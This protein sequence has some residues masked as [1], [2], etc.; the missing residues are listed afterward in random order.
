M[1]ITLF[2]R[3]LLA[4]FR[5]R[6]AW[7]CL[8]VAAMLA[9]AV[10]G[11]AQADPACVKIRQACR[12]AGFEPGNGLQQQCFKPIL[13]GAA[14][15][16]GK[17]LPHVPADVVASCRDAG[18]AATTPAD[19]GA[20]PS[21]PAKGD[22]PRGIYVY[23]EQ[24]TDDAQ[25]EQA[26]AVRGVDGMALV[27]DWATIE[28]SRGAFATATIDSQIAAALRHSLPVELV[29]RAGA[30]TPSW[31]APAAQLK[32][33]YAQHAGATGR[34]E[35][36]DMPP[37]WNANYQHAFAAILKRTA[38]YIRSKGVAISVVKL[39]GIN[40]TSEEVRLPAEPAQTTANCQGGGVNDDAAWQRAKYTPAMLAQAT[41]EIARIFDTAVPSTPVTAAIIPDGGFPAVDAA[42]QVVSGKQKQTLNESTVKEVVAAAAGALGRRFVLQHDY[43][44]YNQPADATVV[45][46]ANA[47]KLPLAWQTN[48]WRGGDGQGAGC[49][50]SAG[51]GA[52]CTDAQ[53]LALLE[54]GVSP[55]GAHGA[56]AHGLYIE[57]FPYDVIAHP[58]AIL[59]AHNELVSG[60]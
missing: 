58:A 44:M 11:L 25:F 8:A 24:L 27:L 1:R 7:R 43:L 28:P 59:K 16:S 34:C 6:V 57:V 45:G 49:G 2:A 32:L 36:V 46:L 41:R 26:L 31:V 23:R 14:S 4:A 18:N 55:A 37:P 5:R 21:A 47:N 53:Y 30:S 50:G 22:L 29:I 17:P 48:L 13:N 54:E 39:T 15:P 40:A 38:D 35:L 20:A 9:G 60:R 52:P 3:I 56:S 42:G 12:T 10:P 33:A 51:H 19:G